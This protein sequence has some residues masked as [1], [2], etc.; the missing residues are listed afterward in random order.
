MFVD[1][2]KIKVRA[3]DG[4]NGAVS[5]HRTEAMGEKAAISSF[6]WM[7]TFQRWPIFVTSAN[8]RPKTARMEAARTASAKAPRIS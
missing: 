5:F 4:G 8:T 1:T 3:G 6:R 2:A 7:I